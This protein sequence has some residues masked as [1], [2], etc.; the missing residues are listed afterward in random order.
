VHTGIVRG[1]HDEAKLPFGFDSCFTSYVRRAYAL[2]K[3]TRCG[4][5]GCRH[6]HEI[7]WSLR[8]RVC[9]LCMEANTVS[10]E[11]L[12]FKFGV[13]YSDLITVFAR[14]I[15]FFAACNSGRDDRVDMRYV[16]SRIHGYRNF[17]YLF[18]VPHLKAL[19][20]LPALCQ[21]QC[22][23]KRSAALLS[24]AVQRRWILQQRF[25]FATAKLHYSIDCLVLAIKRNEKKRITN[26]YGLPNASGGPAWSFPERSKSGKCKIAARTGHC[27]SYYLHL[28]DT[29]VDCPV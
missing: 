4:M 18:W 28:Q 17:T 19:I 20:D 11:E 10:A 6:R 27:M 23:R 5:C 15:F 25:V 16:N 29:S 13:D 1:D 22:I 9:R 2:I 8:M 12:S 14:K 7:Y 21:Q 26:S 24:A 3:G